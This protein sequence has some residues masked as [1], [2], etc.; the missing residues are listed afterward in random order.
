MSGKNTILEMVDEMEKEIYCKICENCK[1][2]CDFSDYDIEFSSVFG[3]CVNGEIFTWK[4][5]NFEPIYVADRSYS[6]NDKF[7][8]KPTKRVP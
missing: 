8:K 5:K 1:H 3:N 7:F 2:N 4:C 6:Y